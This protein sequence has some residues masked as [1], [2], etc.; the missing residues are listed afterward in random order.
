MRNQIQNGYVKLTGTHTKLWTG[1]YNSY[2]SGK[3]KSRSVALGLKIDLTKGAA[4]KKLRDIIAGIPPVQKASDESLFSS[5][6]EQY[7]RLKKG[8]WSKKNAQNMVSVFKHHVTPFLGDKKTDSIKAS[9]IKEWIMERAAT[10]SK[11]CVQ[12]CLTH[13][14]AIFE[15]LIEDDKLIKNPARK[16]KA[17]KTR[18]PGAHFLTLD[19]CRALL[20][21]STGR[22]HLIL[23][24]FIACALRP[25]EVFALRLNDVLPGKLR[26]DEAYVPGDK[27]KETKTEES[28]GF[29]PLAP[30]LEAELLGYLNELARFGVTSPDAFLF[31]TRNGTAIDYGNYHRKV[32]K[33]LAARLGIAGVTF[34]VLRRTVAT[35]M[36]H[37]GQPKTAQALLRHASP[38]I[39]LENYIKTI[40]ADVIA[41]AASWH[42]ELCS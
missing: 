27:V 11:T 2:V 24:L 28:D 4:E 19:D 29:V 18:R 39:T 20:A 10:E 7:L 8:D 22:E 31:H 36:Q 41:A 17:P 16:V 30:E 14:R 3:R 42:A 37:H 38:M 25:S 15:V 23:L 13:V 5:C 26:I 1:F 35:Q 12:K 6:I 32:L 33:P 34:R 40:D 9:D 21:A